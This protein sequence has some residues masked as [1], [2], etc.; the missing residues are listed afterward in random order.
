VYIY[1]Y[2]NLEHKK[3]VGISGSGKRHAKVMVH[4]LR[5]M[6]Y[7]LKVMIYSLKLIIY[8]LKLIIYSL[9]N[10]DIPKTDY[11]PEK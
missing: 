3:E 4:F 8:S 5:G 6:L 9:K 2:D 1:F 11:I 10:R 7:S